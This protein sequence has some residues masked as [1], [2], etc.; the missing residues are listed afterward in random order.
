MNLQAS[1]LALVT[2][3]SRGIGRATSY[4]LA[5]QGY[6][7]A[8]HYRADRAAAEQTL[9]GIRE[10]GS[11]GFAIQADLGTPDGVAALFDAFDRACAEH[12]RAATLDVLVNN[13][14]VADGGTLDDTTAELFDRQFALNV[15]AVFFATQQAVRRMP[16]GGRIVN[17]SSVL[18]S[19]VFEAGGNFNAISAYSA[20]KAAVDTLTRHWAVELGPRGIVVNAVAPGPVDTDMNASWL[21][22]DDGRAT[23]TSASP[24]GRVGTPEDIAG[25]IG[26]LASPAAQWTTGQVIDAS[27]GYRL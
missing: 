8:V 11:D 19:R 16:N 15:K 4:E 5:R 7:V 25:V 20:A 6:V 12:G 24:L 22:T 10:R 2:G 27:G 17:L 13:A 9:A 3:G 21:R 26:F 23:M 14:G 1:K 18:S